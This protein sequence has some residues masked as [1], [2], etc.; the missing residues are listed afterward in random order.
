M[1]EKMKRGDGGKPTWKV[2]DNVSVE[3][4]EGLILGG[5]WD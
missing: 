5:W 4:G 1:V 3:L 2:E